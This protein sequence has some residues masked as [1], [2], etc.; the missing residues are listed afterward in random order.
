MGSTVQRLAK[1]QLIKPPEFV[2]SQTQYEVIM[3]SVAY[4]VS[5]D[6]SDVDV[7]GFCIPN[8]YMVFPHLN[9]EIQG[10]GKQHQRFE[11]FQQHHVKDDSTRKEYDLT[12]YNI[13]KYFQ[14]CMENNPNMIDSLFVPRRC[15]LHC[16]SIGEMVREN[17]KLFLHKG[18][19]HKFK[20][21][22]YSQVHKI[23]TKAIREFVAFCDHWEMPYDID[24]EKGLEIINK[25]S[26]NESLNETTIKNFKRLVKQIGNQRSKRIKTVAE[27]GFDIK[28]A[29]HTV[30]LLNEVE[31]IL[32]ECDLD[33]ERNREQLKS[34]RR[35]E[36]TEIQVIKY[37]EDKEKELEGLYTSS[38]LQHSPDEAKIKQLLLDCLETH[39]GSLE[40]CVNMPNK[41]EHLV[42]D[43]KEVIYKY[44]NSLS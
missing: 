9:G 38:K 34:I 15:I 19:W 18:A 35:G 43:L 20:G 14:L 12:I 33:L 29:Y 7:Y 16:T 23:K 30:R 8:K 17:R 28:F 6:N 5:S 42:Q 37:F 41:T 31:Q 21:Y 3:G 24:L 11:Q 22:A 32:T 36:W 44:D 4:G 27:F 26:G 13:V 25:D 40:K 2:K 10:F 39:F 1:R